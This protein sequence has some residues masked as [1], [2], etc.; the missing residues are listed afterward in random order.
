MPRL[1]PFSDVISPNHVG[2]GLVAARQIRKNLNFQALPTG[3]PEP[4]PYGYLFPELQTDPAALL[5][6]SPQTV[7]A[8]K[9]LGRTMSE[10]GTD[11]TFNSAIP[12]V[13]TY[14]GQFVDHDL[15]FMSLPGHIKLF[16]PN[17]VPLSSDQVAQIINIRTPT[18]DLDCVYGEAPHV[19]DDLLKVGIVE[20]AGRRPPGKVGDEFDVPRTVRSPDPAWDRAPRIGDGRN[21]ENAMITQLHVAFLRA[22]NAIVE[23]GYTYCAARSLLRRYYQ[24]IVVNDFLKRV[25]D[26]TIVAE[27]LSRPWQRYNP[28][29]ED[30]FMPLEFTAAAFRFGHSMVR[31]SYDFNQRFPA[32]FASLFRLFNVVGRYPTLPEEWI[33]EWDNFVEGGTNK[34]RQ[35]DT[36]LVI[37]LSTLPGAPGVS[38]A[39]E[40]NLAIMDLLR[41]YL[42]RLPTGQAVARAL[43]LDVM[44]DT[45][46]EGSAANQTQQDVLRASGLS[47]NTPLWFYILAEAAHFQKGQRLGPVGSTLV[48]G[49]LIAL[50]RRSPGSILSLPG[51]TPTLGATFALPD[52]LR[53]AGVL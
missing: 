35:I 20:K 30:L 18:L 53:L 42:L 37:P 6:E 50:I 16:D 40:I 47:K 7:L 25:A 9:E 31:A 32:S 36:Q 52:L 49:S 8:L 27:M 21:A 41:G 2:T 14:F 29:A 43:K 15:T 13:Y 38:S 39:D 22:H 34:A 4:T 45:D 44:A 10:P 33:I 46:I 51:W 5:P 26:P 17:L 23:G 19:G 12:A 28:A 24:L 11:A 1:R 3:I 48:A